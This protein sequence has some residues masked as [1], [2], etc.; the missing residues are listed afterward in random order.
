[1]QLAISVLVQT[2]IY[3]P[4]AHFL[5]GLGGVTPLP[6]HLQGSMID[7]GSAPNDP[8]FIIHH[9]MMD[10]I[11]EEWTKRHPSSHFPDG[12]LVRDGHKK[13]DY[14]RTFFP[15]I[16]N[17]EVFTDPKEFG[18]YCQLP[19]LDINTPVGKYAKCTALPTLVTA[20][21]LSLQLHLLL[22]LRSQSSSMEAVWMFVWNPRQPH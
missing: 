8:L 19:N 3:F 9:T 2:F 21:V 11:L 12:P 13:S 22:R 5:V 16:T 15:P 18:Y 17:G 4:Q 6:P 1:M 14:L 10:C 7:F 20:C